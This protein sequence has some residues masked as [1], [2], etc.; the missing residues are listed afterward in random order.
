M[1][2]TSIEMYGARNRQRVLGDPF[3]VSHGFGV[4]TAF[5][6]PGL[7]AI[8][9]ERYQNQQE[10]DRDGNCEVEGSINGHVSSGAGFA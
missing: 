6:Q 9:V 2:G 3:A 5:S 7:Y 8:P 1:R 4:L 10:K